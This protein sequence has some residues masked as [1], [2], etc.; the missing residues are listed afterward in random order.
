MTFLLDTWQ[1]EQE[2][3][4]LCALSQKLP[5]CAFEKQTHLEQLQSITITSLQSENY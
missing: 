4:I 2:K 1:V 3:K 5:E